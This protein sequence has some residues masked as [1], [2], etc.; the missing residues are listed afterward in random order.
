MAEEAGTGDDRIKIE[1]LL[2][3]THDYKKVISYN[4]DF[5]YYNPLA[6]LFLGS[7]L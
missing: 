1:N 7:Y 5:Y 2:Y 6:I 4:P 3:S